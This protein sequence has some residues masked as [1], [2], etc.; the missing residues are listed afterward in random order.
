[1][2][3]KS[4]STFWI[5][6]LLALSAVIT[7]YVIGHNHLEEVAGKYVHLQIIQGIGSHSVIDSYFEHYPLT[8]RFWLDALPFYIL[9]ALVMTGLVFLRDTKIMTRPNSHKCNQLLEV[10][11]S[12]Y[13]LAHMM[14]W[15]HNGIWPIIYG[16]KFYSR[17]EVMIEL[18][19]GVLS[20]KW[21]FR[22]FMAKYIVDFVMLGLISL[23]FAIVGKIVIRLAFRGETSQ[24]VAPAIDAGG[25]QMMTSTGAEGGVEGVT[26]VQER[27]LE[28]A[29]K[30]KSVIKRIFITFAKIWGVIIL[31]IAILFGYFVYTNFKKEVTEDFF[32]E[33]GWGAVTNGEHTMNASINSVSARKSGVAQLNVALIGDDYSVIKTGMEKVRFAINPDFLL[34]KYANEYRVKAYRDSMRI[35]LCAVLQVVH[36]DKY[37]RD[38]YGNR[39]MGEVC[40]PMTIVDQRK[41]DEISRLARRWRWLGLEYT[42]VELDKQIKKIRQYAT[43]EEAE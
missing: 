16:I 37:Q 13:L 11:T 34:N 28:V 19:N 14:L 38:E 39:K 42:P 26:N 6:A 43:L 9:S 31:V 23:A 4:F 12:G 35:E 27:S 18:A 24:Q 15:L 21:L 22:N 33:L 32:G 2:K 1:M 20:D 3:I 29:P 17:Q 30:K 36:E 10:T 7:T 8:F 5:G 41:R 40:S 25:S